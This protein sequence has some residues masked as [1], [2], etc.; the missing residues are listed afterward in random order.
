MKNPKSKNGPMGSNTA[1]WMF[2]EKLVRPTVP[3]DS[4]YIWTPTGTDVT[5]RWRLI[6]WVPP[7]ELPEYQ[8]KWKYYQEL[9]LRKLDDAARAE[10]ELLM[11]KHKVA[12]IK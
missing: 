9:P 7:S 6:G 1:H 3:K 5:V 4:E 12:R 2:E 8:K 10:Y 11:K